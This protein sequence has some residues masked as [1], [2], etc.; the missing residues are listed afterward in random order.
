MAAFGKGDW[1]PPQKISNGQSDQS[2]LKWWYKNVWNCWSTTY[3]WR[4]EPRSLYQSIKVHVSHLAWSNH[5][6]NFILGRIISTRY[7]IGWNHT[8]LDFNQVWNWNHTFSTKS[9]YSTNSTNRGNKSTDCFPK[10]SFSVFNRILH[11]WRV[12]ARFGKFS[13]R[14]R[15]VDFK[16]CLVDKV[17]SDL[18]FTV[19]H[20]VPHVGHISTGNFPCRRMVRSDLCAHHYWCPQAAGTTKNMLKSC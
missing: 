6:F 1:I 9:Y 2:H 19:F 7:E 3:S 15:L 4:I 12:T 5:V 14:H 17:L 20:F 11:C 16:T 18:I 8:W 13:H 10:F